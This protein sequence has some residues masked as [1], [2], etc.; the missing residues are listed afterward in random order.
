M[1]RAAWRSLSSVRDDAVAQ[2]PVSALRGDG[3]ASL[4]LAHCGLQPLSLLH[5]VHAYA[6]QKLVQPNQD[7]EPPPST[8]TKEYKNIIPRMEKVDDVVKR[9]LSLEMAKKKEKLKIKQEQWMSRI[10]ENPEDSR[11]LE[12]R[13]AALTVKMSSYEEHMQQHP[14]DKTHKH[15]L[16]M[17]IDQRKKM[18][19]LLQQTN[20]EKACRELEVEYTLPPLHF[21]KVHRS[22][23]AKKALCTRVFQEV[24]K[25]KKQ[26]RALKAAA[27]VAKKQSSQGV[28]RTLPKPYK[29]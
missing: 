7:D 11:T 21:Q 22:I 4:A 16:L 25:G 6:I 15:H 26:R 19:K 18:L 27:V 17:S 8:S 14:K 3:S 29:R 13:V 12:A 2:A 9:V 28:Q 24:Q 5:A 20:Y 23:L 1:L 10:S